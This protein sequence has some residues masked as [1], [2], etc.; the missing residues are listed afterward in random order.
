MKL[1]SLAPKFFWYRNC[2]LRLSLKD[3][4]RSGYRCIAWILRRD[5]PQ[6]DSVWT[7]LV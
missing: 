4:D 7:G 1:M 2:W 3:A 6:N 5:A